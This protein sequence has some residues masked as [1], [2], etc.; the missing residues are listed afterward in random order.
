[1][2]GDSIRTITYT[3]LGPLGR[4]PHRQVPELNPPLTLVDF[5][6][7]ASAYSSFCTEFCTSEYEA[8]MVTATS[9][10]QG[11]KAK[12]A[13]KRHGQTRQDY[14]DQ[15]VCCS[16]G[17]DAH[18]SRTLKTSDLGCPF[19]CLMWLGRPILKPNVAAVEGPSSIRCLR[20]VYSSERY[21]R[22]R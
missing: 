16:R 14:E 17:S 13:E 12:L 20:R 2:Q 10:L 3:I 7:T 6:N 11:A 18:N 21:P 8:R 1:V 22:T 4:A 19:W 5:E 9:T 15:L